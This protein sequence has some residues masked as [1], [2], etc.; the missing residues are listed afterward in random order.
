MEEISALPK[1]SGQLLLFSFMMGLVWNDFFYGKAVGISYPLFSCLFYAL[2]YWGLMI[3]QKKQDP[4]T[5]QATL[6]L[7]PIFMLS[8]TYVLFTNPLFQVLNGIAVPF[9]I[10]VH[11]RLATGS[12]KAGWSGLVMLRQ[13]IRQAIPESL[14]NFRV[15]FVW[16]IL[17]LRKRIDH[18]KVTTFTKVIIGLLISLPLLMVVITLL[19]TADKIF[20]HLLWKLPALI[21]NLNIGEFMVRS[22]LVLG[23]T[24][25][26]F[27]YLW[28][29]LYPRNLEQSEHVDHA[30]A[31]QRSMS[32]LDPIIALT[33]LSA[34]NLVYLVFTAI[35]FSYLFGAGSGMLPS[36]MNVADYARK[37]FAEL[38]WV[39]VINFSILLCVVH[40]MRKQ[41][42]LLGSV[43]KTMLSLLVG[44][45]VIMLVSA[46][47][48]LSFYEEVF[49]Y[50]YTR[51]LVHSFMIFL[52]TLFLIALY[53]IWRDHMSLWKPYLLLA[54]I[55]YVLI[56]YLNIDGIIARNNITRYAGTKKM[57][58]DYLG[59]LS[60]E[61]IPQLV[62]LNEQFPNLG[63]LKILQLKNRELEI[64]DPWNSFNLSKYRARKALNGIPTSPGNE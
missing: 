11:T 4:N 62:R 20:A 32:R 16:L 10:V 31:E 26:L 22:I 17:I 25:Y 42:G 48:R 39:T 15:P 28:G 27:S 19:A 51:I 56:N 44:C 38:V 55:A 9:L 2:F 13:V 29:L 43:V 6:L 33:I 46:Y 54:L 63:V 37:G 64:K 21:E 61:V 1:K 18:R 57:D 34:V 53:K 35:Q 12:N 45:T 52:G 49:G 50:T 30:D 36:D 58:V 7:I 40:F 14:R 41:D 47:V 23:V 24:I 59:E 8:L 3:R 5:N 60:F